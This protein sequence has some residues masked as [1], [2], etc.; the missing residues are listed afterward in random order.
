MAVEYDKK[1]DRLVWTRKL[2]KGSGNKMYG[3][4]VCKALNMP[5]GFVDFAMNVRNKT[6]GK[7]SILSKK[8]SSYNSKKI[9]GMPCEICGNKS[10]DI[11]HLNP[12]KYADDNGFIGTHHKNHLANIIPIC[13][14]CH[15]LV[16]NNEIIHKKVKT[17][18][19]IVLMEQ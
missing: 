1:N 11:H 4:E 9:K 15:N 6:S 13:G 5:E 19:G 17:S 18:D 14:K 10:K 3:L 8:K 16:T 12:Q 2:E 7:T